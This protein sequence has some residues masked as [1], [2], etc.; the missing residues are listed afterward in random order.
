M[1]HALFASRWNYYS[2]LYMGVSLL[3]LP[4][5]FQPQFR[6]L[7]LTLSPKQFWPWIAIET[8]CSLKSLLSF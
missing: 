2:V 5:I 8:T 4:I 7:V 1:A 3:V 6:V